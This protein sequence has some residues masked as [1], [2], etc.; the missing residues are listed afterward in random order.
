MLSVQVFNKGN[1]EKPARSPSEEEVRLMMAMVLE[2][3]VITTFSHHPYSFDGDMRLQKDGAPI[4]LTLS[5]A[6]AKVYM[7]DWC[8][9]LQDLLVV[10]MA[11][12]PDFEVYTHALYVD[13]NNFA[14]EELPPGRWSSG[15]C[16]G[17]GGGGPGGGGR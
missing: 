14:T 15:E 3:A 16:G 9:R 8:S 2:D 6:A 1:V 11:N 4:G 7:L 12:L 10:A 17:G 13:D 5:G